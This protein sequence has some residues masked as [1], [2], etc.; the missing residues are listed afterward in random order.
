MKYLS[1]KEVANMWGYSEET[2]RKWCKL[3]MIKVTICAEKKNGCWQIPIDA[4]CP[5]KTKA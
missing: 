5:R 1:V 4:Q 2:I 3:G